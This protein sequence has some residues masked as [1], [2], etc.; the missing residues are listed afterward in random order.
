MTLKIGL[1]PL[2]LADLLVLGL[3][4]IVL[5]ILLGLDELSGLLEFLVTSLVKEGDI[6]IYLRNISENYCNRENINLQK[7]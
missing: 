7:F 1:L 6:Y 4:F 5:C 3:L 2:G